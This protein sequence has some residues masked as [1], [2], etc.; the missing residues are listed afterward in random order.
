VST[1][2]RHNTQEG[3]AAS[4]GASDANAYGVDEHELDDRSSSSSIERDQAD[5]MKGELRLEF[6]DTREEEDEE[7]NGNTSGDSWEGVREEEVNYLLN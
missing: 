1:T 3:D 5:D 7:E 6:M 4:H 2:T